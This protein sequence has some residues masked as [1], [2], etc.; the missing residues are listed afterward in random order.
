MSLKHGAP[1]THSHAL[2]VFPQFHFLNNFYKVQ[3]LQILNKC[4]KRRHID[5]TVSTFKHS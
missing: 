2:H 5:Y 3:S 4:L 1:F